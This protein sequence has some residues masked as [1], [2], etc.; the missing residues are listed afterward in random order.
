MKTIAAALLPSADVA[1]GRA[2]LNLRTWRLHAPLGALAGVALLS[3]APAVPA[4]AQAPG[5]SSGLGPPTVTWVASAPAKGGLKPGSRLAITLRGAVKDG[6]HVYGL[7]QSPAGPTP[8]RVTLAANGVVKADGAP[9]GTRPTRF[10]DPA[11]GLETQ[12]YSD[13]FTVTVPVRIAA[14]LP[15]ARHLIPLDVRFQTCDGQ[16]CQPPKTVRVNAALDVREGG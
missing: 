5:S 15:A 14:Q 3:L 2:D 7:K 16:I 12:Y 6:W 11:F 4:F 10:H 8:L 13:A 9:V 1:A